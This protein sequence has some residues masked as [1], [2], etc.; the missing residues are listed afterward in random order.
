MSNVFSLSRS[1][2]WPDFLDILA[3]YSSDYACAQ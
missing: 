1:I 3:N 2:A